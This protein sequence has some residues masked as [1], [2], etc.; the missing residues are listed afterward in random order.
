MNGFTTDHPVEACPCRVP[1]TSDALKHILLLPDGLSRS[2]KGQVILDRAG[3]R[4]A[5]LAFEQHGTSLIVDY[6]HASMGGDF[7]PRSGE[8]PAA[9]WIERLEY[10][11]GRGLFGLV[12]WTDRARSLIRAD[13]YR[14]ISPELLIGTSD[15]RVIGI[16]AAALVNRPALPNLPRVAASARPGNMESLQ[17]GTTGDPEQG[18]ETRSDTPEDLLAEIAKALGIKVEGSDVRDWLQAILEAIE[19]LTGKQAS[20]TA[21]MAEGSGGEAMDWLR[22]IAKVL[23]MTGKT[24]TEVLRAVLEKLKQDTL[25]VGEDGSKDAEVAASVRGRLG[26]DPQA[27]VHEVSLAMSM[28]EQ[29]ADAEVYQAEREKGAVAMVDHLLAEGKI[30]PRD[31]ECKEA[32]LALALESPDRLVALFDKAPS[33]LPPQGKTQAPP[34]ASTRRGQ[35]IRLACATFGGDERLQRTTSL[36]AYVACALRDNEFPKLEQG[37]IARWV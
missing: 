35:C 20:V 30:N 10:V 23:G 6:E 29:R 19:K 31:T 15:R 26:L 9:G 18:G 28:R 8:A 17:M 1:A 5:I 13:E 37:E 25:S 14:Y 12:R 2:K 4:A 36:E 21:S 27:G 32:A 33:V 11:P 22:A 24:A 3:A 16:Q 34:E 7:A